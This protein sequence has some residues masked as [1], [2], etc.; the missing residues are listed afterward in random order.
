MVPHTT[1][2]AATRA[3]VPLTPDAPLSSKELTW[4]AYDI[5]NSAFVLLTTAVA[6]IYAQG[7]IKAAGHEDIV[8]VWG[9]T[10]TAAA[11]IAALLMPILGTLADV[12]GQKIRF[13]IGFTG[14]AILV[15]AAMALPLAWLAFLGFYVIARICLNA[16]MTFYD[17]MLVDT[18]S[19][20]RMNKISAYGYAAGYIGSVIPFIACLA[21]IMLGPD[22]LG[23]SQNVATRISFALTALW[24][25]AFTIPLV[26]SYHQ[27]HFRVPADQARTA[28]RGTFSEL[29]ATLRALAKNRTLLFFMIAF[30]FYI[31]AV[32]TVISMST[33]Y[34]TQLGIS[35][36]QMVIALLVTQFVAFP[37]TIAYGKISA[38]VG[39]RPMIIA[40][41]LAYLA[42]VF[43]AAF[44]LHSSTEFWVLAVLVGLFQGGIQA[45]SRSYYGSLIPK[46]RANEYYGFFDIFGKT[47]SVLGTFLV[48]T[49]T[50]LTHNASLGVLSIGALL[51]LALIFLLLPSGRKAKSHA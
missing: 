34:G 21:L 12:E 5:G 41:V 11:L 4:M 3:D 44:F 49:I 31:D 42:I 45:L 46:E 26:R 38:R 1:G 50:T 43:F 25:L 15:C 37:S 10:Q 14:T 36:T 27:R 40:S 17:S 29:A 20:A 7:L 18:T 47:A 16:S 13:Y 8:S 6:P 33:S 19:T 23:I 39:A 2:T 24:W 30:F 28:L 22:T 35:S 9:Y 32:N 51:V 48:A